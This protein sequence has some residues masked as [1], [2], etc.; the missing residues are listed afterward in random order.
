ATRPRRP[1]PGGRVWHLQPGRREA[2]RRRGRPR[3]AGRRG[4][5]EGRRPRGRGP[6]DDRDPRMSDVTQFEADELGW[7]GDFGGRFMPEA[8]VA[9]LDELTDAWQDAM[10][11]PVFVAEFDTILRDYANVPSPLYDATRLTEHLGG[12]R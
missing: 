7:F 4:A 11:D 3:G 5:R 1:G 8:L 6:R 2:V 10:A 9:A 12:A